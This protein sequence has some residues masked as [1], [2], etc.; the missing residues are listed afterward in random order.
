MKRRKG[1]TNAVLGSG[2]QIAAVIRITKGRHRR[3]RDDSTFQTF[4]ISEIER[5]SDSDSDSELEETDIDDDAVVGN[6]RSID[7]QCKDRGPH[8]KWTRRQYSGVKQRRH[9]TEGIRNT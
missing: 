4:D 1:S 6:G 8:R 9:S 2:N 7:S 3:S 5:M